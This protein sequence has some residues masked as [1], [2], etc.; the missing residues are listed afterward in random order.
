MHAGLVSYNM[1]DEMVQAVYIKIK[2]TMLQSVA[3][4]FWEKFSYE[5][6]DHETKFHMFRHAIAQLYRK[7]RQLLKTIERAKYIQEKSG[8]KFSFKFD[9]IFKS[10]LLS[11]LPSYFSNVVHGFYQVSFR[12]FITTKSWEFD[13]D[14][15]M[16]QCE[17]REEC[18]GC[19]NLSSN[20]HC[21]GLVNMFTETNLCLTRM[22]LLD[23]IS[24]FTLTNLIQDQ[25]SKHIHDKCRGNFN[26][27][28]LKSLEL[29]LDT[30]VFEW[31]TRIYNNGS[32]KLDPNNTKIIDSI[33]YFKM[34]LKYFLYEKYANTIIEQFFDI[35]IDYPDSQPAIDDLKLCMEKLDLRAQ[36]VETLKNSI[37]TRL[38]HP[39]VETSDI[40]TGYVATIKAMRHLEKSG[41]LLQ[42]VTEPVKEYL[43]KGRQDTVRCVITSL[44]E[45]TPSDLSEELARSEAI[46]AEEAERNQDEMNNW[47]QWSPDPIDAA[48]PDKHSSQNRKSDIISMIVDIYGSK[49]LFVSE[50][51]NLLAERLLTQLD[52]TPEKEIRNLELLKLRFG[53]NLLHSCEVMLKDISD[54]KRINTHIQ[55]AAFGEAPV[56]DPNISTLI[57]SSQ[58]WPTFKKETMEF[59]E[60]INN[61]FDK[62]KK[63]YEQYKGNRTLYWTPLN[64]KVNIEIEI[65][66]K[67]LDMFV[68]PAQATIIIHFEN[69]KEWEL[70]K[71]SSVMN[72][73]LSVLRR[74]IG[75]WQLQGLIRETK[76]N[77]FVLC[78][79]EQSCD[80]A[81]EA[82]SNVVVEEEE[83]CMASAS[84]QREEELQVFWS[85]ILGM[86]T[87]LDSMPLERI[88]QMLKMFASQ[89]PGFEFSQDELRGFLQR[90]VREHKLVYVYGVYQLPKV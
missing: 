15:Y 1:L 65:N 37:Q 14:E 84:D 34:K 43:R 33:N 51:R 26:K 56:T 27:P 53:E 12:V 21:Q 60:P 5:E 63:A 81:M 58:F 57:V 22:G 68:T 35:I 75:F 88:H 25:I 3:P 52:F 13:D 59:P 90:K 82:Q 4:E 69:Q 87:N 29:W 38:L 67:K 17:D 32:S 71:L 28:H 77:V 85:Y 6:T 79:E 19:G 41:I 62:Y 80:E 72:M 31:L 24:G 54:S 74:R 66:D 42:T 40:I 11:Q 86:L 7:Y 20:C 83:T 18:S 55:G 23:R 16:E 61:L 9:E 10:S 78:D 89:G 45:E 49:E 8:N 50:Y 76:E 30:I 70:E 46:N 64:G 73:P 48:D 44:I 47:E 2:K 36:L 39:G